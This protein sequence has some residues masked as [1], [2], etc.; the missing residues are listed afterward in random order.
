[1][2]QKDPKMQCF[3]VCV[4]CG[5]RRGA[6]PIYAQEASALGTGLAERGWRLVYG[7]GDVG[8]MGNVARAAQAAGGETF[9][10]IPTHHPERG[11]LLG[12][13][14]KIG[15]AFYRRR[16]CRSQHSR[17][18]HGADYRNRRFGLFGSVARRKPR[19]A[20]NHH[21]NPN[22]RKRPKM[23]IRHRLGKDQ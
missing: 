17:F 13:A 23:P 19:P 15:R 8:L 1:M 2:P 18:L 5:S 16:I 14:F 22:D 21:G 20:I 9:G 10:V 3:S 4:Y 6:K 12:S 11:W 7:A